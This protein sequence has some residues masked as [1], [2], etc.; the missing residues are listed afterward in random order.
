MYNWMK[1]KHMVNLF[2]ILFFFILDRISKFLI[3]NSANED[4]QINITLTSFLNLNLIWNDGIAF[5]LLS[6]SER[7]SSDS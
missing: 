5:G 6:F 1:K 2:F 4:G 7:I 3:I